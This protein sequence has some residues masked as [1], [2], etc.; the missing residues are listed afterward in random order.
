MARLRCGRLGRM[1]KAGS[2]DLDDT[3]RLLVLNQGRMQ[4]GGRTH[5][6]TVGFASGL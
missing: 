2:L 6:T 5:G 3:V 1:G 4:R